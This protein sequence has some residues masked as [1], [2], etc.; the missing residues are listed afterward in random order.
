[1]ESLRSQTSQLRINSE[2]EAPHYNRKLES[3]R[4]AKHEAKRQLD[5][6]AGEVA[7]LN[8]RMDEQRAAHTQAVAQMAELSQQNVA[9]HAL[10]MRQ[11]ASDAANLALQAQLTTAVAMIGAQAQG[12]RRECPCEPSADHCQC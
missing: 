7:A 5:A 11:E 8:D 4:S 9:A 1:M 3:E 12:R 2:L 6:M 10:A